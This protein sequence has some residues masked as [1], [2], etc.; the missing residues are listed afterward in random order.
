MEEKILIEAKN[1][2]KYFK[3]GASSQLHAVDGVNFK[4]KRGTT[5]GVV[6]E[7]GCGKSTLGRLDADDLPGSVRFA[8]SPQEREGTDRRTAE[9]L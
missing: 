1:L 8:G 3:V 6:G 4:I 2:K 9:D 7:S 5:L